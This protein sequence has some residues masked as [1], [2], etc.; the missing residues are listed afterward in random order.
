MRPPTHI[1]INS[2]SFDL[3]IVVEF[4]DLDPD[5]RCKMSRVQNTVDISNLW[6]NIKRDFGL[7][8]I[9]RF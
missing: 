1:P 2:V 7:S 3:I 6:D 9:L 8:Q 4:F 5:E